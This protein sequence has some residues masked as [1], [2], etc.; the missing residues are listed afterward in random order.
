LGI[1]FSLGGEHGSRH[2]WI[3]TFAWGA[4]YNI[5]FVEAW[6]ESTLRARYDKHI[7]RDSIYLR[8]ELAY[9]QAKIWV[10]A[11]RFDKV[12]N[13]ERALTNLKNVGLTPAHLSVILCCIVSLCN[14]VLGPN[15]DGAGVDVSFFYDENFRVFDRESLK[16]LPNEAVEAFFEWEKHELEKTAFSMNGEERLKPMMLQRRHAYETPKG[17]DWSKLKSTVEEHIKVW[18][19]STMRSSKRN[20]PDYLEPHGKL[21]A[22]MQS[23]RQRA[24]LLTFKDVTNDASEQPFSAAKHLKSKMP[25]VGLA[26]T[27]SVVSARSMNI[28]GLAPAPAKYQTKLAAAPGAKAALALRNIPGGAPVARAIVTTATRNADMSM[29]TRDEAL[30]AGA[31][32][33]VARHDV[34]QALDASAAYLLESHD[35][36]LAERTRKY[37]AGISS[38]EAVLSVVEYNY[39]PAAE[40]A[41][42]T[43]T[44]AAN[45][46]LTA[47]L[48]LVDAMGWKEDL[49][50]HDSALDLTIGQTKTTTS[51]VVELKAALLKT[52]VVISA[53]ART[54]GLK[55]IREPTKKQQCR[56]LQIEGAEVVSRRTEFVEE[57]AAATAAATAEAAKTAD[58]Q[59]RAKA[60]ADATA[61]AKTAAKAAQNAAK[62]AAAGA[63]GDPAPKAPAKRRNA[64][65]DGDVPASKRRAPGAIQESAR[66]S[67]AVRL[68]RGQKHQHDV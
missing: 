32:G 4:H 58:A 15:G 20:C 18:A 60:S 66:G 27:L 50:A 57:N 46:K 19:D 23:A 25:T 38:R 64:N 49:M 16:D 14:R 59:V 34:A 24:Q 1:P 43:S 2:D 53:A 31:S 42:A 44:T 12:E 6:I 54:L 13:P 35:A 8:L 21:C 62:A 63:P 28:F 52:L 37:E 55:E 67:R 51:S 33:A 36:A 39:D 9:V 5:S 22:S 10:A 40:I 45:Q 11:I 61:K 65:P 47:Q 41:G 7:L 48:R 3:L 68:G 29:K 17:R 26:S 30:A 56:D